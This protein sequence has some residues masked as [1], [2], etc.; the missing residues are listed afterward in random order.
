[1]FGDIPARAVAGVREEGTG[2]REIFLGMNG[3]NFILYLVVFG[4]NG[5]EPYAV[6]RAG[7]GAEFGMPDAQFE[8]GKINEICNEEQ[9]E[10]KRCGATGRVSGVR[11]CGRGTS[12]LP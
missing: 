12:H 8:P 11:G 9:S 4:G 7:G 1:M 6:N 10:E 2:A 5:K 3:I